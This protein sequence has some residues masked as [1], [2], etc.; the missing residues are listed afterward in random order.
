MGRAVEKCRDAVEKSKDFSDVIA[1]FFDSKS[2]KFAEKDS[3]HVIRHEKS[4]M[5]VIT[6]FPGA[7]FIGVEFSHS[8]TAEVLAQDV[9]FAMKK[10]GNDD[11]Y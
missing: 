9:L 7:Q 11:E 4:E 1:I 6:G 3:N 5:T 2:N 8:K 10:A